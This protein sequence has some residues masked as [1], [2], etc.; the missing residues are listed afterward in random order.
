MHTIYKGEL[1]LFSHE[2]S[3]L[4][5]ASGAENPGYGRILRPCTVTL[6]VMV[7]ITYF[8]V[9]WAVPQEEAQP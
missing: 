8:A 1:F 7:L 9:F 3:E 6:I 2:A 4:S 5:T